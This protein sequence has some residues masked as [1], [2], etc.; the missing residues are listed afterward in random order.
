MKRKFLTMCV[1][2]A[3]LAVAGT[4]GATV[5]ECWAAYGNGGI[6]F[7]GGTGY[8][9]GHWYSYSDGWFSQWF[10]DH[11]LDYTRWKEIELDFRISAQLA[12]TGVEVGINWSKAAWSE[13]L[14]H[15]ETPPLPPT[16]ENMYIGRMVI[17]SMEDMPVL[18]PVD[19]VLEFEIPESYNPEWVSVDIRGTTETSNFLFGG[20][21]E[22]NE[23]QAILEHN[24]VPEPATLG[25][26]LLGGLALL[27]HKRSA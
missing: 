2:V 13:K 12:G 1:M 24:C 26:L 10:Y 17:W 14:P 15:P 27:R 25:V 11:P 22:E 23:Y 18:E 8:N 19:V 20:P 5:D 4:A 7:S 16:N 3:V 6:M 9:M 21:H